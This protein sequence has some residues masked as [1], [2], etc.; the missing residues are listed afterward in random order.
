[1]NYGVQEYAYDVVAAVQDAC[2]K[3]GVAHPTI[4][5][6]SGRAVAA[7][8][9]VLVFDALGVDQLG[10]GQPEEPPE[11][12]H[13]VIREFYDTWKGIQPK[14]VQEAWHD[15]QTALEESRS[16]FKFGY[17]GLREL[18][19]AERLFWNCAEK[20]RACVPRLKQVPEE[21]RQ[22]DELLGSIYYCNFSIFQSAPDIW[23]MEQLFPFIPIHR[24][25]ERPT[26]KARLAD[27]T[28]DS[29]GIVDAFI[30]IE[31]VQT[32]LD[33]HPVRSGERYF[34]AMFLGGAYQEILGDL[35]NL[36]GDTN[37]VHVHVE[38]YGY[39]VSN[40]IKGDAITDVLRF[41]QYDPEEMIE[42][43]R[44]QA[45][46]ALNAGRMSLDQLRAFMAHYDKSLRGYTYLK[47][48]P[49]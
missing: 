6:E 40:V 8:Q 11:G 42:R 25:E 7:H 41:L 30:D 29:D 48:E 49:E 5:S 44:K 17:L 18:A 4:V 31:E 1:M 39:S 14:N 16:L 24:L 20:I 23:A 12:C 34:L 43:V 37:A 36:F 9:S 28:C 22:L 32:A 15:A 46:R 33:V 13:R 47:G 45:E 26:V 35:H 3:S 2:E 19:R 27:L 38:D 10:F 21:L